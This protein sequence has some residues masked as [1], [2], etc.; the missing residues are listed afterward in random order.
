MHLG[1]RCLRGFQF[2]LSNHM[3]DSRKTFVP[4]KSPE[5][6]ARSWALKLVTTILLVYC[7][8]LKRYLAVG[9]IWEVKHILWGR[10]VVQ[11]KQS[12]FNQTAEQ[13][14]AM[15]IQM[16]QHLC[17]PILCSCF[18]PPV[19]YLKKCSTCLAKELGFRVPHNNFGEVKRK[20]TKIT[21]ELMEVHERLKNE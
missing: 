1:C 5:N 7:E 9:S 10:K 15:P 21:L 13:M 6:K 17:E 19:W 2:L 3:I 16:F 18:S 11:Q 14:I 20:A 8:E 12:L 4:F